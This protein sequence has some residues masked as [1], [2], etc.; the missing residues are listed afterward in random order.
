LQQPGVVGL[1]R[2]GQLMVVAVAAAL[3]LLAL[4]VLRD[5]LGLLIGLIALMTAGAVIFL[6]VDGRTL[7]EWA[8]IVMRWARRSRADRRGYR[9]ITAS[10]GV[11]LEHDG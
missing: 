7:D 4:Y 10:T 11:Q 2:F 5:F 3:A 1:L 8:P 9:S 6:P